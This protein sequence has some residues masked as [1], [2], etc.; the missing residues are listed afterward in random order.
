MENHLNKLASKAEV[1]L[2][3]DVVT[4]LPQA[5]IV[6]PY[7]KTNILQQQTQTSSIDFTSF[8]FHS[9]FC[10]AAARY[11]LKYRS[12]E[13][14]AKH[15]RTVV[16]NYVG[17][18]TDNEPYFL[19]LNISPSSYRPKNERLVGL[20]CPASQLVLEIIQFPKLSGH[21]LALHSKESVWKKGTRR[22][23]FVLWVENKPNQE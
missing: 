16:S 11:Y 4:R 19:D 1:F 10:I 15:N 23:I 17:A 9:N 21:S 13:L 20:P 2:N 6:L 12:N 3:M 22:M 8:R 7:N 5:T 18:T 14:E